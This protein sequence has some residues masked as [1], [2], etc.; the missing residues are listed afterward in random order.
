M[1]FEEKWY[2]WGR[3]SRKRK[4]KNRQKTGKT[5]A[6]KPEIVIREVEMGG[7]TDEKAEVVETEETE[8]AAEAEGDAEV[9][10]EEPIE[11]DAKV[12]EVAS[13]G[14]AVDAGREKPEKKG[15]WLHR[16][17]IYYP[18][19]KFVVVAIL[20][21]GLVFGG[22]VAGRTIREAIWGADGK[23]E[24]PVA[25]GTEME[26]KPTEGT[27]DSETEEKPEEKPA[28]EQPTEEKP[29]EEPARPVVTT[30]PAVTV[31]MTNGKKL[32]ALTFDDGPSTATTGRLLDILKAKG[33]KAT[34]FVVGTMASR[35]PDL[36]K[37]EV[38]EGHEV[39]SHSTYHQDL[40]KLNATD[41]QADVANMDRIFT[42]T[43]GRKVEIMRPPYGSVSDIMRGYLGKPMIYWS[44]DPMDWKYR[45]AA[46][47]R[48]NVVGATFDG[49]VVLMHDIHASTVDA[50]AGII[51]DLRAQGYEFLTVSELAAARGVGLT[52]GVVYYNFK[53]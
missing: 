31:P 32:V 20:A 48:A 2:N 18:W 46:T 1:V 22:F 10:A 6:E 35:A 52:S 14:A 51:D 5:T 44:V 13:A 43:L 3:M 39:G 17:N 42:E 24:V 30:K 12:T 25:D 33:V 26:E 16:T 49:A 19:L 38:A 29:Q 36:L 27:S 47:V 21:A 8:E 28:E 7:A 9:V 53:P 41:L 4:T 23:T 40:S 15:G 37:R 50:V 11:E 34:F 45:D